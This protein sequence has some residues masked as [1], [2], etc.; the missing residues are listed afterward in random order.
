MKQGSTLSTPFKD[1][2]YGPSSG[3]SDVDF[4]GGKA[5]LIKGD[6][7]LNGEKLVIGFGLENFLDEIE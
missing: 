1:N 2:V 6:A 5:T 7:E 4:E 3:A